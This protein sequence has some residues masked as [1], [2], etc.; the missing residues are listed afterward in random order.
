V[1]ALRG[2]TDIL[3]AQ[4]GALFPFIPVF[5]GLGIGIFFVLRVEPSVPALW[6]AAAVALACF[7][8]ARVIRGTAGALILTA[9]GL[10]ALG[11]AHAGW[12]AHAVAAPVLEWRYYGPVEGRVMA[13]S[14][15]MV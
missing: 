15:R 4:R 13:V 2:L 14:Q 5:F 8:A 6:L 11:L 3:Q 1:A 12:R 7:A 10:T 9:A